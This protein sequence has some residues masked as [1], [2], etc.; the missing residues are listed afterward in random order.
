MTSPA[1]LY[2]LRCLIW[3][4]VRQSL[5][6]RAFW[7]ML[8]LSGLGILL[9]LSIGVE[10]ATAVRPPGEIEL[11]G[12]DK[13]PYTGLN[14]GHGTISLGFGALHA[15]QWRDPEAS[16]VFVENV[17]ALVGAGAIGMLLLLLWTSG[18]LPEFLQ[19]GA[20][21]VL[22]AKPAPRWL[23]LVGKFTGVLLFVT[24]LVAVFIGGTWAALGVRTGIWH[25]GYL[26]CIPLLMLEFTVL[27]SVS[28]LLAVWTRSTVIC[29]VGSLAFWVLCSTVNMTRLAAVVQS[30]D[31]SAPAA[32]P[33]TRGLV[34]A[35]YWVLPKPV[36]MA[37]SLQQA[38][39]TE[40]HFRPL[41]ELHA[42]QGT[43][44]S[45]P[46]L[47]ALTSLLFSAALLGLAG[48]R[49]ATTDY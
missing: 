15:E 17:L 12:A 46:I 22:L 4:T 47:S 31:S 2:V 33:L 26:I 16:V 40:K 28:A 49:L 10:G 8:G 44:A 21:T 19:P 3:D 32:S 43:D 5:A 48:R 34:E 6:S 9:C 36:D 30:R 27:Y 42:I 38:L 11:W 35:G 29:V 45:N 41:P 20:A 25:L 37:D 14:R 23:L 7:L 13:Q 1:F 18:F 39:Q 24:F